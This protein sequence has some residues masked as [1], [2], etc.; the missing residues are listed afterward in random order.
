MSWQN[1][2][3]C[4]CVA[5]LLLLFVAHHNPLNAVCKFRQALPPVL[6]VIWFE[7]A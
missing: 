5:C 3:T 1:T 6:H 7:N 4:K 2:S